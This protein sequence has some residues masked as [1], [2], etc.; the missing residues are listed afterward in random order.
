MSEMSRED[1]LDVVR[2][3]W[4]ERDPV[5]EQLVDRMQAAAALAASDVDLELE[6]MELVER[7]T[8]L[9]G[10]RGATAYTLR[11]VY[12][13]TDLL[14]RIAVE[15]DVSRVDGWIVPPQPMTVHAVRT[16]PTG[17]EDA[18]VSD[19]GDS[20]RF[21]LADLPLGQLQLKLEPRDRAR[22]AIATP[23]FEI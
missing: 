11:F 4:E 13:E 20:G 14:L 21:V 6:L 15:G 1:L 16:S 2:R 8:E 9:A 23:A 12:G 18:V 22:T 10:A 17:R 7:S 5:P 19:V 3:V